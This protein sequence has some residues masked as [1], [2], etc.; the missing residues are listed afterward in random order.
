MGIDKNLYDVIIIGGGPAGLNAAVVLGRCRRKVL[1]FDTGKQRNRHSAGIHNYLTRDD[2]LPRDFLHLSHKEV[3]KYG[4]QIIHIEASVAKKNENGFF[5]VT[6]SK[7]VLYNA[8]KI[9]IATGLTDRLPSLEG[10]EKYFGKSVFHCPYCDGWEVKDKQ[11]GVYARNKNGFDLALSLTTWSHSVTYFTDGK[12][13]LKQE[14]IS[15]LNKI[16]IP[17]I[18]GEIQKLLGRNG[19][20]TG[21]AFKNKDICPCDALFFVNGYSQQSDIVES[22]GC[23]LNK[24]KVVVTNR[25]GQTNI[26][27]VFVAGDASRDMHFVVV[28]AAEGAK[29]GVIINKEL[30]KEESNTA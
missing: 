30:Q 7:G 17:V 20:L 18:T 28:A 26:A 19:K 9:L 27:G 4:V 15:K 14:E 1:L 25:F 13:K 12:N 21:I 16:G 24:K 29:A 11:I 23:I 5:S 22:L 10:F 2:I 3:R 8:K 6:D